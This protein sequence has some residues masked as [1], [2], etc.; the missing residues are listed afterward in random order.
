LNQPR[1][2]RCIIAGEKAK[3]KAENKPAVVLLSVLT[4]AKMM[5]VVKEPRMTGKRIVK[6]KSEV[7]LPNAS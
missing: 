4:S 5:I 3:I 6:S 7:P 1:F 2:P